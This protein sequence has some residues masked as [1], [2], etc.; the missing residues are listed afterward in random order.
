MSFA[1]L[2]SPHSGPSGKR[3]L[4]PA[5][6]AGFVLLGGCSSDKPAGWVGESNEPAELVDFREKAR[7]GVLWRSNL[8]DSGE[9]FFQPVY[10]RDAVYGVSGKGSLTRLDR[11]TGRQVWR[12]DSGVKVSGG[13]GSG[14]GLVLIGSI[15][16]EVLAYEE[17]GKLRWK[18]KVSSEVLSVPQIA[19]GVVIVRSGDGRIAGLDAADGSSIWVFERS[20]PAL[21]VRS[22]AGVTIQR[23]IAYAGFSGGKLVAIKV[24]NGDV[25]WESSV[26]QPRG[27]TELE[28]I[29]DITS[30]PAV[31]FEQVCAVSFQ[32]RA[33][34][35]HIE[36]GSPLWNRE[37]S[38]D[39][40][41]LL[42]RKYLYLTD[43]KGSVFVLDK[44]SG[45]TM[46][47][48]DQ[49]FMRG[50][51]APFVLSDFVVVGDNE[52]FLHGLNRED[53]DY[54]ARIELSD[55]IRTAPIQTDN[56]LLVQ[57]QDGSLYSLTIK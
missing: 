8:G 7:F 43:T 51:T 29:S 2:F 11:V 33:A 30:N 44:A 31:D 35:F 19:D 21:V 9:N 54:V 53:G 57:T 50:V 23:G 37:M 41:M 56:G 40:G 5:L 25:L 47:K 46:W 32:G 12:V 24:K 42:L 49:L 4:E 27:N 13:V 17:N 34:C 3:W 10:T 22:H 28:R 1:R 15:K 26:S 36:N 48:N 16:G 39:K 18:S 52:G 20:T 6:L 45:S 14:E 38:S 55:A